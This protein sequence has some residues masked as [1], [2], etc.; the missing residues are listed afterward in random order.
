MGKM[1][2]ANL[3]TEVLYS[4]VIIFCSLMIY[5]GTKDLYKLSKHRGIKYF[6]FA[7]LFFALAYF[8]R[9]FIKFLVLYFNTKSIVS[10]S[11]RL[12][13]PLVG[14]ISLFL[15]VYLG[16]VAIF[17]LIYSLTW[18]NWR[19]SYLGSLIIHILSITLSLIILLSENVI[20]YFLVNFSLFLAVTLVLLNSKD[21]SRGQHTSEMFIVYILLSLFWILNIVDLLIPNMFQTIQILIYL[22]SSGIFMLMLYKV[23]KRC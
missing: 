14:S 7:F 8:S 16:F 20:V 5:I 12:L 22:I 23:L 4:F 6:R 2:I 1:M 11:P 19:T 17:Y 21:K 9:S 10:I 15:F 3:G 13:N 18:K